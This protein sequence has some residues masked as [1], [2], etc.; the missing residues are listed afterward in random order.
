MNMRHRIPDSICRVFLAGKAHVDY[1]R[2]LNALFT[3]KALG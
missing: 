2:G 3:R 1:R